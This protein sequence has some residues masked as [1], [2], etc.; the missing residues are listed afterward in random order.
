LKWENPIRSS[1]YSFDVHVQR[2][3]IAKYEAMMCAF[4]IGLRKQL[5]NI[6]TLD[7]EILVFAQPIS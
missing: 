4:V 5:K 1:T 6:L 3:R 2:T 7:K